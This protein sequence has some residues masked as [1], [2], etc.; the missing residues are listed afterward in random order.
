MGIELK[1]GESITCVSKIWKLVPTW[2]EYVRRFEAFKDGGAA[3]LHLDN[4][5]ICKWYEAAACASLFFEGRLPTEVE[6]EYAARAGRR[7]I[8]IAGTDTGTVTPDN[9]HYCVDEPPL[10][11]KSH[12][13]PI[14]V[15]SFEP[16]PWGLYDLAGNVF[17]WMQDGE[18]SHLERMG[19]NPN[20]S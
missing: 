3:F 10:D 11:K 13:A 9:A 7:G 1:A 5:A 19:V 12:L 16:N 4:P 17:E 6:Y 2:E 20:L 15:K 14:P 8:R 18:P